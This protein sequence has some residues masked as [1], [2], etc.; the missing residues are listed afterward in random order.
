MYRRACCRKVDPSKGRIDAIPT[1]RKETTMLKLTIHYTRYVLA[2]LA[3]VGF[4]VTFN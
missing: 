4:G 3:T 1:N 2:A